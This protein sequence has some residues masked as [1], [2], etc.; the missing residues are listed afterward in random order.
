VHAA[1]IFEDFPVIESLAPDPMRVLAEHRLNGLVVDTD[2]L[3]K[4]FAR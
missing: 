3:E 2:T 1:E 4:G